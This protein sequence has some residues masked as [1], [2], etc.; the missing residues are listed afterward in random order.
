[1]R[2]PVNY[3]GV[4]KD[5]K[6]NFIVFSSKHKGVDLGWNTKYGG[7]NQPIYAIADGVCVY[8]RYQKSGGYVIGI[9]HKQYGVVSEY[10]HL[11]KDSQLIKEGQIVKMGQKIAL[12]GGTGKVSGNHLHFGL[13]KGKTLRY[14]LFVKWL[15]PLKYINVYDGQITNL[16]TSKMINHTKHVTTREGLNIRTEPSVKGKKVYTAKY[17]EQVETYGVVSNWNIVDNINMYY[18]SNKYLQ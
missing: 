5:K 18:C 4:V 16:A 1:M 10:G 14:G 15:D 13:Q 9:Y 7:S 12:M 17:D 3:A 2:C 11:K 6:G 8:N